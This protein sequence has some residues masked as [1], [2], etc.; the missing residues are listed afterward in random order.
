MSEDRVL[1]YK[2][3]APSVEAMETMEAMVEAGVVVEEV[4][5]EGVAMRIS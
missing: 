4:M 5:E 2:T 3:K 1:D